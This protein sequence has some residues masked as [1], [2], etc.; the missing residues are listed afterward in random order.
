MDAKNVKHAGYDTANNLVP[1]ERVVLV[2]YDGHR[3]H[4]INPVKPADVRG[5]Q[6]LFKSHA[7]ISQPAAG[8]KKE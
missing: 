2:S 4:L 7:Q 5:Y 1:W 6:V 8:E 3:V